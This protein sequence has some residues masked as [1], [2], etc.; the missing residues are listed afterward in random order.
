MDFGETMSRYIIISYE[1][2]GPKTVVG[3][4]SEKESK[5]VAKHLEDEGIE[6]HLTK[7]IKHYAPSIPTGYKPWQKMK[8]T[9]TLEVNEK[10]IEIVKHDFG[11]FVEQ[12]RKKVS[13]K[14]VNPTLVWK[15]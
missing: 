9:I 7:E 11:L 5:V 8:I 6:Y 2:F 10:D 15:K 13:I 14:E 1:G 12:L 4:Y 3:I